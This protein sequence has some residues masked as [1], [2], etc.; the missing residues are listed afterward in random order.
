LRPTKTGKVQLER[1]LT[2]RFQFNK[3]KCIAKHIPLY[4]DLHTFRDIP[5]KALFFI[6]FQDPRQ[7]VRGQ[8]ATGAHSET[9]LHGPPGTF[10]L[11]RTAL[12]HNQARIYRIFQETRFLF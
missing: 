9:A 5:L 11:G 8:F 6:Y 7:F 1:L 4:S 10:G 3:E 2:P 12:Q